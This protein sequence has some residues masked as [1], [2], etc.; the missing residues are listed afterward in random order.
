MEDS[1]TAVYRTSPEPLI[2]VFISKKAKIEEAVK[3]IKAIPLTVTDAAS[4]RYAQ[5]SSGGIATSGLDDH[6]QSK[7][8]PGLYFTG[9]A[10]D[11]D[12]ACGG[13]NLQWAWSSGYVAGSSAAAGSAP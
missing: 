5:V 11:A 6:L 9:E 4:G 13:Y 2:P 1:P 7:I 8:V 3:G 12:G 10:V